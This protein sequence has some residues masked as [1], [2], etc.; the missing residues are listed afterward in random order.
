MPTQA[1]NV[2][3]GEA[4]PNAASE[5]WRKWP[6]EQLWL[7]SDPSFP[8]VR[9]RMRG[10]LGESVE[11]LP[12]PEVERI[13]AFVQA[14]N[15]GAALRLSARLF[16]LQRDWQRSPDLSAC[17]LLL[18]VI[19]CGDEQAAIEL[20]ALVLHRLSML[21][22]NGACSYRP[23]IDTPLRLRVR[24]LGRLWVA[25]FRLEALGGDWGRVLREV[26]RRTDEDPLSDLDANG[27]RRR[28]WDR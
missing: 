23:P 13:A 21:D 18:A 19:E 20:A 12:A 14:G 1:M 28:G 6:A 26:R 4:D 25:L 2:D 17:A 10:A 24:L 8:A 9:T 27:E 22:P 3:A 5:S 7:W 15:H 11:R 16:R